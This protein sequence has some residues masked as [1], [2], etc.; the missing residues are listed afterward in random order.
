MLA[1]EL[2]IGYH[3]KSTSPHC[4]IKFDISEAFDIIRW[5]FITFDLKAMNLPDQF[6]H[7]IS[8]CIYFNG[9]FLVA[10]NGSFEEFFTSD[11]VAL[12]LSL[13]IWDHEQCSFQAFK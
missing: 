13:C 1:F 2:V 4:A 10:V 8:V 3:K 9:I 12:S 7:W 11:K 6:I 5:P